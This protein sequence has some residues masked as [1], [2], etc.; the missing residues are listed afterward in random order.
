MDC[1]CSDMRSVNGMLVCAD[2]GFSTAEVG[3]PCCNSCGT[4]GCCNYYCECCKDNYW[5]QLII[6][7]DVTKT[8]C[9]KGGKDGC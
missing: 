4:P 2:C 7:D 6:D 3:C 9:K 8:E 1:N 5:S